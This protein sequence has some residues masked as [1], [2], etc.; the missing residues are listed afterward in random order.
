MMTN[1]ILFVKDTVLKT[2]G[3]DAARLMAVRN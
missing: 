2:Q 1:I 3:S